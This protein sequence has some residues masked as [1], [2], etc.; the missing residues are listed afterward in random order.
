MTPIPSSIRNTRRPAPTVTRTKR[1]GLF[2]T[3]GLA[4]FAWLIGLSLAGTMAARPIEAQTLPTGGEV[5]AGQASIATGS[6]SLTVS[7]TSDRAAINWQS[8]S[9]GKGKS[10][11][12][13]QPTSSSVAL[14]RVLGSDPSVILGNLSANGKVFLVNANGILFGQTANVNVGGLVASTLNISDADFLAGKNSFAGTSGASVQNDGT[15]T[16]KNGYVALLG[17]NVGNGG[18][19]KAN[20]GTVVLAGGEAITL[21]VAGDGLLNVAVDKGAVGALVRNGGLIRADSVE[22]EILPPAPI[23]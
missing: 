10:V 14:N 8:F 23:T 12:F 18:T 6:K 11:V 4:R 7:Q 17:A 19:I 16:A 5:V 13:E 22:P 3:T 2:G 1:G 20:F 15:I 9:I 21:D